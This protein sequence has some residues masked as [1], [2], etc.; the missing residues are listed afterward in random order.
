M[1]RYYAYRMGLEI[2]LR[3]TLDAVEQR[4]IAAC[5]LKEMRLNRKH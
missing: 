3:R 1:I 5:V 2:A 4:K